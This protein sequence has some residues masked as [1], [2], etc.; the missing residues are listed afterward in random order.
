MG[1]TTSEC[2]DGQGQKQS[3]YLEPPKRMKIPK[4]GICCPFCGSRNYGTKV[5][6]NCCLPTI[7]ICQDCGG[8]FVIESD[9]ILY[10]D[11]E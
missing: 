6:F 10:F 1:K 11:R 9:E 3:Q 2:K 4:D 7:E 5:P 8:D